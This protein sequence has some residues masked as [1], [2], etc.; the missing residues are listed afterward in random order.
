MIAECFRQGQEAFP[1]ACKDGCGGGEY[2][3]DVQPAKMMPNMDKHINKIQQMLLSNHCWILQKKSGA[4]SGPVLKA[5]QAQH[6]D[7]SLALENVAEIKKFLPPSYSRLLDDSYGEGLETNYHQGTKVSLVSKLLIGSIRFELVNQKE[8]FMDPRCIIGETGGYSYWGGV[9]GTFVLLVT[10][11]GDPQ[12]LHEV[13]IK[14]AGYDWNQKAMAN[15]VGPSK[16]DQNTNPFKLDE[17]PR[18]YPIK[19]A[20]WENFMPT[21]A[22]IAQMPGAPWP[23]TLALQLQKKG[24][25]QNAHGQYATVLQHLVRLDQVPADFDNVFAQPV[26]CSWMKR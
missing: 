11:N 20:T 19:G 14:K 22:L 24:D 15:V 12:E 10:W 18:S 16:W 8:M 6:F 2:W 1:L 5:A 23:M 7:R 25:Y 3:F 9:N 21:S 13:H 4:P 17:R 26:H